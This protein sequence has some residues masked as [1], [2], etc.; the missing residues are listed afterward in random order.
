[1]PIMDGL[2]TRDLTDAKDYKGC[3]QQAPSPVLTSH[4]T[5]TIATSCRAVGSSSAGASAVI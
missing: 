3:L 4:A 2:K 1:M 5:T